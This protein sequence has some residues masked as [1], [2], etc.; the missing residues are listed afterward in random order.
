MRLERLQAVLG[1]QLLHTADDLQ[2]AAFAS[3]HA[4][5]DGRRDAFDTILQ[6]VVQVSQ[7]RLIVCLL[8]QLLPGF[9]PASF[10]QIARKPCCSHALFCALHH[11]VYANNKHSTNSDTISDM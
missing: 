4:P 3:E 5:R 10:W 8:V 6:G 9:S 7:G 11:A 2:Q 1:H